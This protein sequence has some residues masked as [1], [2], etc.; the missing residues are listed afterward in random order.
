MFLKIHS[1]IA[2]LINSRFKNNYR[3][4]VLHMY[5]KILLFYLFHLFLGCALQ[6]SVG[7]LDEGM[8]EEKKKSRE[9][10]AVQRMI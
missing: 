8:L 10:V 7:K 2:V 6:S 1:N 5:E 9:I 3:V 4:F